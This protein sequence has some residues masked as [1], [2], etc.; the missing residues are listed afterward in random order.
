MK[1]FRDLLRTDV[2][3]NPFNPRFDIAYLKAT[4]LERLELTVNEKSEDI[5][6]LHETCS[7]LPMFNFIYL[8]ISKKIVEIIRRTGVNNNDIIHLL[9][10][11]SNASHL[12]VIGQFRSSF[13]GKKNLDL[14]KIFGHR[15]RS[16]DPGVGDINTGGSLATLVDTLQIALNFVK[17]SPEINRRA[18]AL[19]DLAVI[20]YIEHLVKEAN[21]LFGFKTTYEAAVWNGGYIRKRGENDY[22]ATFSDHDRLILE[23]IG[24]FRLQMDSLAM[25]IKLQQ[26][27]AAKEEMHYGFDPAII[28]DV[29]IKTVKTD[30]GSILYELEN[31]VD[32]KELDDTFSFF[33]A[34]ETFYPYLGNE[35][36]PA[37][38][39]L[40]ISD[41]I[42]LYQLTTGLFRKVAETTEYAEKIPDLKTMFS[43][44]YKIN[45]EAL[46]LY[47]LKRSTYDHSTV[48][49]FLTLIVN[50]EGDYYNF[51]NRPFAE[52]NDDLLFPMLPITTANYF[53]LLDR[54][55]EQ[56]GFDL[57]KR[58]KMLESHVKLRLREALTI[59]A[60]KHCIPEAQRFR[61]GGEQE[62]IDL[63]INL[64][65]IVVIAEV[66]C[67]RYP[68]EIR[69]Y[70]NNYERLKKGAI[71]LSRKASFFVKN[72]SEFESITKSIEGKKVVRLIITN[73]PIF[74]G[75]AIND[76]PVVDFHW[77][78][79]FC[80]HSYLIG[81]D[82]VALGGKL[83]SELVHAKM[84]YADEDEFNARFEEQM[85]YPAIIEEL[86]PSVTIKEVK[87]SL[88][89]FPI[90][91]SI[92]YA[93]FN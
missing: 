32:S 7:V 80:K 47:L 52:L 26:I 64:Q 81:Y 74:A 19:P 30:D 28:K 2:K 8:E 10:A 18:E 86:K 67:I 29:R 77:L 1:T 4:W 41:I 25:D 87:M 44:P 9:L 45:K 88:S 13:V 65:S 50:P 70:Y 53:Y 61:V 83:G 20:H 43:H 12:W 14:T 48:D 23:D 89:D 93:S 24:R 21:V 69:D 38:A 6:A 57:E 78:E 63:I 62:E 51:W 11:Q 71:Q 84:L 55:L 34:L 91:L 16:R 39:P 5:K 15:T 49:S 33:S 92:E 37:L 68:M 72:A 54:W 3:M 85:R 35:L 60:F 36:L 22:L 56:G 75:T 82:A 66:K 42:S 40:K 17:D 58:G 46:R 27:L 90:S 76:I 73:Y 31:G 79:S 59:K